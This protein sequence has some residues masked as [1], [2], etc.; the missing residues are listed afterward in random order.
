MH[1]D[2]DV[3]VVGAGPA[4]SRT[5]R[6]LARA[7]LRVRLLEEH[8]AIGV[9]SHCSGLISLR[10]LREAEIGEEAVLH[11]L[12][13]AFVHTQEGGEAPILATPKCPPLT[14]L[15]QHHAEGVALGEYEDHVE[16]CDRC[17]RISDIILRERFRTGT[18]SI[19]KT[20]DAVRPLK[21]RRLV[22]VAGLLA[23]AACI[24]ILVLSWTQPNVET[25]VVAFADTTTH[26]RRK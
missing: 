9:P 3:A 20:G 7:G 2:C 21:T 22:A 1:L 15:W 11:R 17:R 16:Q 12:T 14:R 26:I 25:Q 4:G 10:T 8:R 18:P 19:T 23:A 6:D 13:G 24:A 5:A